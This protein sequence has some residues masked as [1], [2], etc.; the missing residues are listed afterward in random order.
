MAN[1]KIGNEDIKKIQKLRQEFQNI[2]LQIGQLRFSIL[3]MKA[4]EK[5]LVEEYNE[6]KEREKEIAD[7]F[8]KK[9]GE[10]QLNPTTWEFEKITKNI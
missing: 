1:A 8:I 3:D 9:Y 10:G 2:A 6:L 5:Y 7:G 4:Q